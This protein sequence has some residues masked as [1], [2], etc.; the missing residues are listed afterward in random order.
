MSS[1]FYK[2]TKFAYICTRK[3]NYLSKVMYKY[4]NKVERERERERARVVPT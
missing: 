1:E 3:Q 4:R 2:V